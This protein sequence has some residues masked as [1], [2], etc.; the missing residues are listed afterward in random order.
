MSIALSPLFVLAVDLLGGRARA[1]QAHHEV[2][3]DPR[4][5]V[6]RRVAG[7]VRRRALRSVREKRLMVMMEKNG[8]RYK[9]GLVL[10]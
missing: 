10:T 3:S 2:V 1:Q 9:N 7:S 5:P 8:T 6:E 4:R